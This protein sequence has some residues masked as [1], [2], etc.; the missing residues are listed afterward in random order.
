MKRTRTGKSTVFW[1]RNTPQYSL[2]KFRIGG[3]KAFRSGNAVGFIGSRTPELKGM[4]TVLTLNPVIAT[5]STNASSFML[6]LIRAG[7]NSQNRVGRKI[8]LVSIRMRGIAFHNVG[9]AVTSGD[10]QSNV[11][12]MVLVWD[13]QPSGATPTYESIFGLTSQDGTEATTFLDPLRYDNTGRFSVIKD[14]VI[15]MPIRS[16]NTEGGTTDLIGQRYPFDVFCKLSGRETVFSGQSEPMTIADIS[17]GAL[18]VFFR[19]VLN[20]SGSNTVG[21]TSDSFARLR[22]I[23]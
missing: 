12:R 21:I 6:N 9:N 2:K 10:L 18:Y 7:V 17:S 19:T 3:G 23:D 15:S 11:L 16:Q 22:Y 14:Q 1:A 8:R 20:T 5:T 4:D 13:K